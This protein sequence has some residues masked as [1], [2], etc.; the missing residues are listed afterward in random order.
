MQDI[1]NSSSMDQESFC[2]IASMEP[3]SALL[4]PGEEK[5]SAILHNCEPCELCDQYARQD[6]P[7]IHR[8]NSGMTVV[9]ENDDFLFG[10]GALP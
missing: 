2:W 7:C 6:G 4:V 3:E 8:C 1:K 5:A 10:F 9:E